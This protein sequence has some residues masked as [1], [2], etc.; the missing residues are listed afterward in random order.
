MEVQRAAAP[1]AGSGQA[2]CAPAA[3]ITANVERCTSRCHASMTHP[4]NRNASASTSPTSGV[5]SERNESLRQP[6][7]ARHQ[8][9]SSA[10][11]RA[12]RSTS[13][14][15]R[16]AGARRGSRATRVARRTRERRGWIAARAP[17]MRCPNGTEDGHATSQPRHTRH[18][19]IAEVNSVVDGRAAEL[20]RLHRGDPAARRRDL[21]S[22]DPVGGTRGQAEPA[23]DARDQLVL[24]EPEVHAA[25][26]NCGKPTGVE[27]AR[28]VERILDPIGHR[29]VRPP[30]PERVAAPARRPRAAASR[31]RPRPRPGPGRDRSSVRAPMWTVPTPPSAT[32]CSRCPSSRRP[33]AASAPGR[34]DARPRCAV[35]GVRGARRGRRHQARVRLLARHIVGMAFEQDVGQRPSQARHAGRKSS[36]AEPRAARRSRP[37]SSTRAAAASAASPGR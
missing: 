18:A 23:G 10:R 2:G 22:G 17:S 31:L 13:A 3:R 29:D 26:R 33:S 20:H 35:A 7:A 11:P 19:S 4:V 24:V 16:G 9:E 21:E 30:D 5:R 6:E 8:P 37:S 36:R 34:T 28:R 27:L 14:G 15:A 32:R 1:G 25:L 12:T